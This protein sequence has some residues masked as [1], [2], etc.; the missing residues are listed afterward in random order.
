MNITF[1]LPDEAKEKQ[2]LGEAQ[3]AGMVGLAGHRSVGGVRASI[4][5]AVSLEACQA[6]ASLMGDFARRHGLIWFLDSPGKIV[7]LDEDFLA[8]PQGSGTHE[9]PV[10]GT[11]H[12]TR[13]CEY[14]VPSCERDGAGP[15]MLGAAA[16]Q[17]KK[18]DDKKPDDPPRPS[19]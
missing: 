12:D 10:F 6:L 7:D 2:F 15:D 5:N 18:P 3:A 8:S 11:N 9:E 13:R 4:Y 16:F 19:S 14:V 1:R 17:D